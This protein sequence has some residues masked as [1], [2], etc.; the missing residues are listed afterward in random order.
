MITVLAEAGALMAGATVTLSEEEAHHLKVRRAAEGE[1][2]RLLDGAGTVAT[3]RLGWSG[4]RASASIETV[5]RLDPPA[6]LRLAVGAGDRDRFGWLAE[7]SAEL[8][9]TELVPLSTA[10]T[11]AVATRIRDSHLERLQSRA[12][13]AIKQSGAAWAPTIGAPESLTELCARPLDG[14]R[15]L[16]LPG[17]KAPPDRLGA[18]AL[19]V[20]VGPEGGWADAEVDQL[21]AA[22]FRPVALAAHIL[23]FETAAVA[24]AAI[25]GAARLRGTRD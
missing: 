7:K 2:M 25:I 8:G 14:A 9:V 11:A 22:G 13:E 23:R 17:G 18:E 12:R 20:A 15:W 6:P 16:A 3:G 19:T 4:K 24:A 10:H 5:E 1:V 21:Q